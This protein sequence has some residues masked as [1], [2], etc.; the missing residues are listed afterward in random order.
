MFKYTR[1]LHS[2]FGS[3]ASFALPYLT[4]TP[5]SSYAIGDLALYVAD[6]IMRATSA[7]R[8]YLGRMRLVNVQSH[9]TQFSYGYVETK[10]PRFG[11]L[12]LTF[13]FSRIRKWPDG[14]GKL[15]QRPLNNRVCIYGER[16]DQLQYLSVIVPATAVQ[17]YGVTNLQPRSLKYLYMALGVTLRSIFRRFS[18][19]DLDAAEFARVHERLSDQ[20]VG[21]IPFA[22]V[23][24]QQYERWAFQRS[25]WRHAP[26]LI[27][28]ESINDWSAARCL[29]VL[30]TIHIA[31]K[32]NAWDLVFGQKDSVADRVKTSMVRF[33]NAVQTQD[34]AIPDQAGLLFPA[35]LYSLVFKGKVGF[36][37]EVTSI[38]P[39]MVKA[40]NERVADLAQLFAPHDVTVRKLI[41]GDDHTVSRLTDAMDIFT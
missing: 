32:D 22:N 31:R 23:F 2:F 27:A 14:Q 38:Y 37:A 6:E 10:A 41:Q 28:R 21:Q 30:P 3:N 8:S 40:Y 34:T 9:H 5:F 35:L 16:D 15:V 25:V 36:A 17:K 7:Y 19:T 1:A 4:S 11:F 18:V 20:P 12:V 26:N 29:D 39:D 33:I 24:Q 13:A